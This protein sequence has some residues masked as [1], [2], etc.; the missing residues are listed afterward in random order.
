MASTP[1]NPATLTDFE[2]SLVA[3]GIS[4]AAAFS[5]PK[6]V[7]AIY[8]LA[9]ANPEPLSMDDFVERLGIA[10]GSASQGLRFLQRIGAM[11]PVYRSHQRRT[12]YQPEES[13]RRLVI[14]ILNETV[15]PQL[16]D[17][18]ERFPEL[19]ENLASVEDPEAR[20]L[21]EYRLRNLESWAR[22]SDKALPWIGKLIG[23]PLE[24]KPQ[25]KG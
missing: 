15:L 24:G 9:Y 23:R 13:V 7:G 17:T 16:R 14:G 8:G 19:R 18:A 6:S 2:E 22:K 1:T 11:K 21:L 5:L 3:I 20:E 12:L 10:V 25:S 4:A